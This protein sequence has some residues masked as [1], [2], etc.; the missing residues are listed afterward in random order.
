MRGLSPLSSVRRNG[1]ASL[2][3][4]GP[5]YCRSS[6]LQLEILTHDVGREVSRMVIDG[7]EYEKL[8]ELIL[9]PELTEA[10]RAERIREFQP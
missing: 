4:C 5:Y 1:P 10:E 8:T 3:E 2:V 7:G 6:F 9:D